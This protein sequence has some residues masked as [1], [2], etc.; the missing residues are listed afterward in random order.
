MAAKSLKI[1]KY[2]GIKVSPG[3]NVILHIS[4]QDNNKFHVRFEWKEWTKL[5]HSCTTPVHKMTKPK[6]KLPQKKGKKK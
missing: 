2:R 1:G 6:K 3:K 4:D 5:L